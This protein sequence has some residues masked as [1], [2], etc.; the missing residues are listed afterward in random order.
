MHLAVSATRWQFDYIRDLKIPISRLLSNVMSPIFIALSAKG[1]HLDKNNALYNYEARRMEMEL[2]DFASHASWLS[3]LAPLSHVQVDSFVTAFPIEFNR[4][5]VFPV[6]WPSL[7]LGIW[8]MSCYF[9]SDLWRDSTQISV[10]VRFQLM[11][12]FE[13]HHSSLNMGLLNQLLKML[14]SYGSHS[15]YSTITYYYE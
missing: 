9:Y 2:R 10:S 4:P 5:Q 6:L 8:D 13:S 11:L 3:G 12:A 15:I 14:L 1:P 7:L